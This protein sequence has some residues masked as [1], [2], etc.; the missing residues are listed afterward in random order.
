MAASK[1]FRNRSLFV[2]FRHGSG[3]S[4]K[5][6]TKNYPSSHED[7]TADQ[8]DAFFNACAAVTADTIT[9]KGH[10]DKYGVSSAE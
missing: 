7:A 2:T 8:M 10:T 5:E 1:T 3:D 4:A 6:S 9:D